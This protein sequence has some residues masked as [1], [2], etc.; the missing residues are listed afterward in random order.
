MYL[1]LVGLAFLAALLIGDAWIIREVQHIRSHPR[2]RWWPLEILAAL[3]IFSII[4]ALI[5]GCI[6]GTSLSGSLFPLLTLP[7][8]CTF[9]LIVFGVLFTRRHYA[10]NLAILVTAVILLALVSSLL[11]PTL[12]GMFRS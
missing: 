4:G 1:I 12:V 5:I 9:G 7:I 8:Q 2:P 11:S 10:S 3:L 6:F